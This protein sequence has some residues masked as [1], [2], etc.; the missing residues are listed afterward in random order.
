M[1]IYSTSLLEDAQNQGRSP[2]PTTT[3]L[4][5][6]PTP[7]LSSN[8]NSTSLPIEK[9]ITRE[10]DFKSVLSA[11]LDP[12][13]EMCTKMGEMRSLKWDQD[14]FG[15][16]CLEATRGALEGFDFVGGRKGELQREEE[17]RV[18]RLVEDHVRIL[19][20]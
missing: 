18:E 2:N 4:I 14:V 20:S 3:N 6:Y 5:I 10:E 17:E 16:N 12:V 19:F 13:L 15:V 7:S 8:S 1:T 11:A 9:A